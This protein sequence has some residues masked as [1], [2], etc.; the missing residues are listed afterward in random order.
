M[1]VAQRRY[2]GALVAALS[3]AV[4]VAVVL[5]GMGLGGWWRSVPS[6][7]V[8]AW[9]MSRLDRSAPHP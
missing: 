2:L 3:A 8:G 5:A 9:V 1:S 4:G 7:L 6:G